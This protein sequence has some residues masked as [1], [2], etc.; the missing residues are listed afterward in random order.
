MLSCRI[1]VLAALGL[2]CASLS[3]AQQS[4]PL[5]TVAAEGIAIPQPI[6]LKLTGLKIGDSV[7]DAAFRAAAE[8]LQSTGLFSE[9]QYRYTPGPKKIGY[10]LIFS[11]KEHPQRASAIFDF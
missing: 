2:A 6:L 8:K 7:D 10:S 9:V 5:E 1:I 4:F 3:R 11:L